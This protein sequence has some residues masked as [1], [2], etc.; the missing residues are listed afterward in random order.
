MIK[1]TKKLPFFENF[2]N[3]DRCTHCAHIWGN[4]KYDSPMGLHVNYNSQQKP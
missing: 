2:I 1:K 4:F 3:I